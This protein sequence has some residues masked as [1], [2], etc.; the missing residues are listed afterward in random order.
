M[1]TSPSLS[2]RFQSEINRAVSL[3]SLSPSSHNCQPW[4]IIQVIQKDSQLILESF[5]QENTAAVLP[6]GNNNIYLILALNQEK[7]LCS[8]ES[9]NLEMLLS[10]GAFLESLVIALASQSLSGTTIWHNSEITQNP[11]P[12]SLKIP[13]YWIPLTV[14]TIQFEPDVL[15]PN[16]EELIQQFS[17]RIT[18]RSP[19]DSNLPKVVLDE[20]LFD[21]KSYAYPNTFSEI[22]ITVIKEREVI[23]SMAKFVSH[24]G[25]IEFTKA[26]VWRETYQFI[27]FAK[28]EQHEYGFPIEQ[29]LEKGSQSYGFLLKILLNPYCMNWLKYLRLPHLLASEMGKLVKASPLLIYLNFKTEYPSLK[30]QLEGGALWL[31]FC[32]NATKMGLAIHP[33]SVILQHPHLRQLFQ[34]SY[35]LPQGRGF[36]FCR[37]GQPMQT[38]SPV[39]KRKNLSQAML[40]I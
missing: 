15:T 4:E 5:L 37:L 23:D 32:L 9:H 28:Q 18:H 2:L 8:L 14:L 7:C 22:E 39:L 38:F 29:L 6:N 25:E 12:K 34:K 1:K 27:H 40:T 35:H 19:Y 30:M 20:S 17:K 3:A 21:L 16:I 11:L 33:V 26:E 13:S 24:Y 10:C 31:N 36:F